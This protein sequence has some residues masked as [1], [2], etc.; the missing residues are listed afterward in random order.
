MKL[1]IAA[2]SVLICCRAAAQ[3]LAPG[4]PDAPAIELQHIETEQIEVTE[5]G[6]VVDL[7][8][9]QVGG[10]SVVVAP[11]PVR[12]AFT[13]ATARAPKPR[14]REFRKFRSDSFN[15]VLVAT[16]FWARG[17]DALST[18]DKLDNP[19]ICYRE[20]SRFFGL[21]M[22]PVFKSR[23]GAYS[24]SFGI[25][26]AYSLL[27]AHLWNA[28]R[29]HPHHARLLQRMSRLLL[30]GDSSMEIAAG[31]HNILLTNAAY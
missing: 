6:A 3:S 15:R 22:T 10:Y 5:T 7:T 14:P 18:Y 8:S 9:T 31:M 21:D 30:I 25:A 17:L 28:G 16:E 26:A 24:Y 2:L 12:F 4:V 23:A 27:A 29:D 13:S 20:A 11:P 1:I 19:C